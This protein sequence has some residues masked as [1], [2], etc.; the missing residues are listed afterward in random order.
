ME[1]LSARAVSIFYL[2]SEP[3][4]YFFL[5][6][7]VWARDEVL[8]FISGQGN[9]FYTCQ[10]RAELSIFIPGR[11]KLF[12]MDRIGSRS[13]IFS[14]CWPLPWT[15]VEFQNTVSTTFLS[16]YPILIYIDF[17][18]DHYLYVNIWMIIIPLIYLHGLGTLKCGK[19]YRKA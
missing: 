2:F 16:I 12:C 5:Y 6:M 13:W 10:A 1:I 14:S 11:D 15:E 9:T 17:L 3:G 4:L 19:F 18:M 8:T 7:P